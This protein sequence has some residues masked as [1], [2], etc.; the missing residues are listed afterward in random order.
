MMHRLSHVDAN[1]NFEPTP[2]RFASDWIATQVAERL[3]KLSEKKQV[4]Y[5]SI[6]TPSFGAVRG[7]MFE[8]VAHRSLIA[9]DRFQVRIGTR[10]T[11]V[12]YK[13]HPVGRCK[14]DLKD[15]QSG[16]YYWPISKT[17]QSIDSFRVRGDVLIMFQ[18]TV[19]ETHGVRLQGVLDVLKRFPNVT[20][21][22]LYFVVPHDRFADFKLT[23][24]YLKPNGTLYKVLPTEHKETLETLLE[25][26]RV[27]CIDLSV[28]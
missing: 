14:P 26:M 18:M 17:T 15:W 23:S 8:Q 7:I 10:T 1:A 27:L 21:H 2:Y 24:G 13:K 5:A 20:Q 9:G 16:V 25:N 4:E 11:D 12:K 28:S 3:L 22:V 19:S 6:T